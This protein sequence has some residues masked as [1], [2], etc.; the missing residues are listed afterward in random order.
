MKRMRRSS[1]LDLT[2]D[3]VRIET[4]PASGEIPADLP[5]KQFSSFASDEG[6]EAIY[7]PTCMA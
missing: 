7:M 1:P 3:G 4:R 6:L 2:H 5:W